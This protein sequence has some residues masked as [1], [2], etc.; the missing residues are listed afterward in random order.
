MHS[1]E[2]FN[3]GEILK[4]YKKYNP[5]VLRSGYQS[6]S[7]CLDE[8]LKIRQLSPEELREIHRAKLLYPRFRILQD[9]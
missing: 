2:S 1:R 8:L 9:G 6:A 3:L 7:Y 4:R 5:T